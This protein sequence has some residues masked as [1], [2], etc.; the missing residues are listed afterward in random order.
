MGFNSASKGLTYEFSVTVPV[1]IRV[2]FTEQL[3]RTGVNVE[4]RSPL[5][6]PFNTILY[7]IF[8]ES[9]IIG[10]MVAMLDR[11]MLPE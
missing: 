6:I 7:S 10:L 3:V 11:N 8:N 1:K 2:N 5:S 9:C 4:L